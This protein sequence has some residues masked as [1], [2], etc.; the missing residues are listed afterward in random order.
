MGATIRD[1]AKKAGVSVSTA[2]R[3]LN[4]SG[5]ASEKTR[6][7]VLSAV[8]A[9]S[10]SANYFARGLKG[11]QPGVIGLITRDYLH[12]FFSV[13]CDGVATVARSNDLAV[14]TLCSEEDQAKER[15]AIDILLGRNVTKLVFATPVSVSNIKYAQKKGA[16]C[17][18]IERD[19]GYKK[20][21]RLLYDNYKAAEMIA[22]YFLDNGMR[23]FGY[24]GMSPQLGDIE[25]LRYQGF[26]DQISRTGCSV[27][28]NFDCHDFLEYTPD[29][30]RRAA[31]Q[32]LNNEQLPDAVMVGS[33]FLLVGFLDGLYRAGVKVP[34]DLSLISADN[35]YSEILFPGIS[36]IGYSSEEMGKMALMLLMQQGEAQAQGVF[37]T[38]TVS[39]YLIARESLRSVGS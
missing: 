29:M 36:C 2:S 37:R 3:V 16:H 18:V 1:V 13:V 25:R 27:D 22:S 31:E 12:P 8:E 30:G 5:Y 21:D 23:S 14:I 4:G 7:A 20:V 10:Y 15:S 39:P 28:A 11:K 24:V 26:L 32:F 19:L 34:E 6:N 38:M 9:V 33:D 35:F 17:V